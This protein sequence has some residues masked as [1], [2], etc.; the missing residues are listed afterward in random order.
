MA[1]VFGNHNEYINGIDVKGDKIPDSINENQIK[2]KA[3]TYVEGR[4][5]EGI[6]K[7]DYDI[8]LKGIKELLERQDAE[9][10]DL[11]QELKQREIGETRE[12][13]DKEALIQEAKMMIYEKLGINENQANNS[14]IENFLKGIVDELV[15]GNYELAIEIYNTNGKVI[16]ESL[17]QLLTWEGIK[18][19]A[20]SLGE[21][22]WN[23]FDGNAYE[24]G[25]SV[26][27][28]GLI[29]TGVGLGV[30]V[31]K[32]AVK[33][34]MKEIARLRPHINKESIVASPEIRGVV[35]E[36]GK[37]VD[38]IVPKQEVKTAEF[39]KKVDIERQIRGLEQLGFSES[40]TR[41]LLESGLLTPLPNVEKFDLLKR[42]EFFSKKGIDI[43]KMVDEA[44]RQVPNLTREEALLIFSYT[45]YFLYGK[46]NSFMRGDKKLLASLTPENIQATQRVIGKLEQA[47]EKMPNL[48]PGEDGFIL[49]GDKGKYWNGKV[50]DEVELNSFTSVSNNKRDIFLGEG[51]SN[52]TQISILG[53]EG[54][55]KDISSLA[56]AVNFGD[57]LKAVGKTTNEGVILPNSR[58]VITDRFKLDNINYVN[59]K[60][61]K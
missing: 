30:A 17:K 14:K 35:K 3:R 34:G 9:R 26:A 12:N 40:F 33:L 18:K 48:K 51:H 47:L 28:L 43:N 54:R 19:L 5:K 46:L 1:E 6:S 32:K 41:D 7:E 25:K 55:I 29:S 8:L 20:E 27:Q 61:T 24:K 11:I 52:D 56:I 50:G 16:I 44:I 39:S 36:T 23:L 37:Q 45:D 10:I 31:G 60:Q 59:A 15:I 53:K 58:V 38:E 4:I 13:V 57:K 21:T 42:F 2:D 22:I 49:R